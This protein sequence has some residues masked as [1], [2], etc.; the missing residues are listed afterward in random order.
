MGERLVGMN[1]LLILMT[2]AELLIMATYAITET[3]Q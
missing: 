3:S 2:F 1:S